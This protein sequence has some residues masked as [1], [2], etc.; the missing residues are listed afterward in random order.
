M[1]NLKIIYSHNYGRFLRFIDRT[2]TDL[3]RPRKSFVNLRFLK[4]NKAKSLLAKSQK[5]HLG[6][7]PIR[8]DN[9]I[10]ID[11]LWAP[12][13]DFKCNLNRLYDY[14]PE[15]SV[16]E[17]YI[18][19]ALEHF[20]SGVLPD[21]LNQFYFILK[22]NGVLRISVPDMEKILATAKLKQWSDAKV[23]LLQG[24]TGGGQD[25]RYNYHK[26]FFWP[27]YLRRKLSQAGFRDIDEYPLRPHF[28]GQN[29]VDASNSAGFNVYGMGLSL[30]MMAYK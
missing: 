28:S 5:L 13:V 8:L 2:V 7:G 30:N 12:S 25:H 10:N 18:C 3:N 15:N 16:S 29:I 4:K 9:Y 14:F 17:I 27:D 23:E 21:Y 20:S 26:S 22:K 1:E 24:V 19:H 11:V 6:C